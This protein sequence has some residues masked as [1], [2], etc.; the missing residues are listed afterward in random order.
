MIEFQNQIHYHKEIEQSIIGICLLEPAA[1]GKIRSKITA[2]MFY[3]RSMGIIF[4][5]MGEMADS[6]IP[7][8]L[9]TAWDYLKRIK[10]LDHLQDY[11]VG[12]FLTKLTI[13]VVHSAHLLSWCQIIKGM[14]AMRE[15]ML[16]A[17]TG[18]P[19]GGLNEMQKR[20]NNI[21]QPINK[22]AGPSFKLKRFLLTHI[23]KALIKSTIQNYGRKTI[24]G[25]GSMKIQVANTTLVYLMSIIAPEH[26]WTTGKTFDQQWDTDRCKSH[27]KPNCYL[28][29]VKGN[30]LWIDKNHHY[31]ANW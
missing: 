6:L 22:N 23:S 10:K 19:E 31:P 3:V 26:T 25:T 4:S 1:F 13:P 8:D 21:Q 5:A 20:I 9:L 16:L 2:D 17:Y 28:D 14:W 15:T 18:V 30:R 29:D 11:E 27:L 24:I 12:P 7:I